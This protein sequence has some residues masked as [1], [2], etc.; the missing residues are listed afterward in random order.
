MKYVIYVGIAVLAVWALFYLIRHIQS[1]IR[2]DCGCG[3]CTGNC[4]SCGKRCGK[5]KKR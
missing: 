1:Q 3:G 4:T 5:N 2:G